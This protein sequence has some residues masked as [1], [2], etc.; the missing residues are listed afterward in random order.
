MKA[1]LSQ[2]WQ[3]VS[4]IPKSPSPC[5]ETNSSTLRVPLLYKQR[6]I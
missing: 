5:G 3:D 2:D 4:V 1:Q 6:R